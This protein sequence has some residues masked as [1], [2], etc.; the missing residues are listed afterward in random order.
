M[1]TPP[2]PPAPS[3]APHPFSLRQ[4]QYVIA[5]ADELS[6]RR[7]ADRCH[8]SQP[9][10]SA[11]LAQLE[12]ALGVRLFER[13]RRRVLLTPAGQALVARA[14]RVLLEVSD[15][16][17]AAAHAGDPLVGTLRIGVIPTCSPYLLP[18]VTPRLRRD[19]ARLS[20]QWTED[21]TEALIAR[22]AAGTLDA[23]VVAL[24]A[25]LGEVDHDVI[26]QDPFVLV[27]PPGHPL[28]AAAAP[29]ARDDLRGA[30]VL[31]LDDGHCF[32]DQALAFCGTAKARELA[33]RATSL[34]TLVQMVASG[35]GVTLLPAL[36]VPTEIGR[37][38]LRVRP[39]RAPA[40]FRTLALIW[41]PRSPLGPALRQ[42]TAVLRAAYAE[43]ARGA[44]A[45]RPPN[46]RRA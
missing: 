45:A 10:L 12:R 16:V 15:L 46:R 26:A 40:P 1:P 32:R 7:A 28:A 42:I 39:F 27:A 33:F 20:V 18:G 9:S 14:R 35:A 21:K 8:V 11:Q 29:I 30:S 31:L 38:A 22:L 36:S 13:D 37:A 2:A 34:T 24:E 5:V 4:L 6:F 19:F 44:P 43:A 17:L 3:L 23:A 25:P 41:R